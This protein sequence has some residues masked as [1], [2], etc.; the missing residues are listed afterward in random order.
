MIPKIQ[1]IQNFQKNR[2]ICYSSTN[3]LPVYKN[4]KSIAQFLTPQMECFCLRKID[5]FFVHI[6]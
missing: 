3:S 1:N 2:N 4:F 5:A 6:L